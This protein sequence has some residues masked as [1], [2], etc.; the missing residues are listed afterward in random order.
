MLNVYIIKLFLD[1]KSFGK[2]IF[3][4]FALFIEREKTVVILLIILLTSINF[5]AKYLIL[6]TI[7]VF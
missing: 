6:N 4:M 1:L 5:Y 7:F 2:V 3:F